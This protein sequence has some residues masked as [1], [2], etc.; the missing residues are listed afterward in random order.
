MHQLLLMGNT[1]NYAELRK[2][3]VQGKTVTD[4]LENLEKTS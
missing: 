2:E 1:G 4:I 3:L